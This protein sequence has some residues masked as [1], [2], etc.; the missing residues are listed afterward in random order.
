[1]VDAFVYQRYTCKVLCDE[2]LNIF[3]VE[4]LNNGENYYYVYNEGDDETIKMMYHE[5]SLP[6]V[7]HKI[8]N[9]CVK[10]GFMIQN[11]DTTYTEYGPYLMRNNQI[12]EIRN[13]TTPFI[14]INY[15]DTCKWNQHEEK[16]ENYIN[17]LD[18]ILYITRD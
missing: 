18:N 7:F 8:I 3:C 9:L 2:I 15:D 11:H 12:F 14:T 13:I 5:D 4:D 1:M 16:E 6:E 17:W 10:H